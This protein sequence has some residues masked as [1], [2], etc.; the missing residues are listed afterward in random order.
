[1]KTASITIAK[2]T[3]IEA[4]RNKILLFLVIGL[5]ILFGLAE[6]LSELALTESREISVSWIA[7]T[8]RLFSVVLVSLFV[9]T[10]VAREFDDKIMLHLFSHSLKRYSYYLGKLLAFSGVALFAM[11]CVGILLLLY[12]PFNTVLFWSLSFYLELLIVVAVSLLFFLTFKHIAISFV[13]VMAFYLL[14]RNMATIQLIS[15]SPIL[16]TNTYSSKIIQ[17]VLDAIAYI[18][19]TLN[20][21]SQTAW[22]I[23]DQFQPEQ[24]FDNALQCFIYV[25]FISMVALFDLYRM[26]F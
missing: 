9:M 19:P 10:S 14:A 3:F 5:A 21:F 24:L 25:L 2:F 17:F 11:L 1:M 16:E 7:F 15:N 12:L 6:F 4:L 23:Y 8:A 26:E 18:L 20:E 22:L 13:S